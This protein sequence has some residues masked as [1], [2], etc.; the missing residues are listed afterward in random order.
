MENA[1]RDY[2]FE[3]YLVSVTTLKQ[4]FLAFALSQRNNQN[5]EYLLQ[6]Y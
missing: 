2:N 3:Y 6:Y 1:K 5:Q 4:I